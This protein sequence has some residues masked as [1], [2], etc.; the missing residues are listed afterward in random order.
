MGDGELVHG[1][2]FEHAGAPRYNP[3]SSMKSSPRSPASLLDCMTALWAGRSPEALWSEW[4]GPSL[5]TKSDQQIYETGDPADDVYLLLDGLMCVRTGEEHRQI[6]LVLRAP[7]LWGELEPMAGEASRASSLD[8]VGV[9]RILRFD[10]ASLSEARRDAAFVRWH[11]E[12]L[13]LRFLRVLESGSGTWRNLEERLVHLRAVF[14][15]EPEHLDPEKLARLNGASL[16]AV[17]RALK[18][19]DER[20]ETAASGATGTFVHRMAQKLD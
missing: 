20:A 15:A 8:A 7:A 2:V 12:D 1:P 19:L 9:A 14:A 5:Q 3:A 17:Q 11:E 4:P 18:K 6:S 16:K 10:L 13:A